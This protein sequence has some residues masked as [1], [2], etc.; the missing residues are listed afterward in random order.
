MGRRARSRSGPRNRRALRGRVR[1]RRPLAGGRARP[2]LLRAAGQGSLHRR[3]RRGVRARRAAPP[4]LR[5]RRHRPRR[6]DAP[7][8]RAVAARSGLRRLRGE[9]GNER[10]QPAL[11]RSRTPHGGVS[12][13]TERRT[14]RPTVRPRTRERA[15]RGQR[16]RVG[17]AR[18]DA[19]RTRD[20]RV[21]RRTALARCLDGERR[22]ASETT[23]RGRTVD[24]TLR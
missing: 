7:R 10:L 14:G 21:D 18:N 5:R 24:A 11:R 17:L 6:R 1:S 15:Q 8:A 2:R 9:A 23:E 22:R 3:C 19:R 20:A 13:I 12:P 16:A 4:R